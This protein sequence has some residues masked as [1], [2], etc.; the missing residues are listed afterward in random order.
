M[1]TSCCCCLL[2]RQHL[3]TFVDTQI[4]NSNHWTMT[5]TT[6]PHGIFIVVDTF[7]CLTRSLLMLLDMLCE[8]LIDTSP[9]QS[10]KICPLMIVHHQF[11]DFF[12]APITVDCRNAGRSIGP[13]FFDLSSGSVGHGSA[14]FERTMCSVDIRLEI[15]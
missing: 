6:N 4:V 13:M 10:D 15:Q 7:C 1:F 8:C 14:F 2:S 9:H 3:D 12:S 5:V 11:V